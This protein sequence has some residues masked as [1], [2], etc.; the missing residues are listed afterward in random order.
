M[1]I[2]IIVYKVLI[3]FRSNFRLKYFCLFNM[4]NWNVRVFIQY[5]LLPAVKKINSF[6]ECFVHDK[7]YDNIFIHRIYVS[8]DMKFLLS[9]QIQSYSH[10]T[11]WID[12]Q[13]NRCFV[14]RLDIRA[15][16]IRQLSQGSSA[17][18]TWIFKR[19]K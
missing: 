7:S 6:S 16:V 1:C 12:K 13:I 8:F 11:Q 9:M 15:H 3:Y 10:T 19:G 2:I 4:K 5:R 17:T 14:D 18:R